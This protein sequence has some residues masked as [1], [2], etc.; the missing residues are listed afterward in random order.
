MPRAPDLPDAQAPDRQGADGGVLV[1]EGFGQHT[2]RGT[3]AQRPESVS[4]R[5]SPVRRDGAAAAPTDRAA[6]DR[7]NRPP[8]GR[9]CAPHTNEGPATGAPGGAPAPPLRPQHREHAL[10]HRPV[11]GIGEHL[12]KSG[13]DPPPLGSEKPLDARCFLGGRLADP[14]RIR[15]SPSFVTPALTTRL[16]K[17]GS[18]DPGPPIAATELTQDRARPGC[19]VPSR[20][21]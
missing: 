12:Q 16:T 14:S 10:A 9:H 6:Q 20:S 15:P 5:A 17:P 18:S 1:V 19:D 4:P 13:V 7:V 21:R 11:G 2:K 8:T 3:T